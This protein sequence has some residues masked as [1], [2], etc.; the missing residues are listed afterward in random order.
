MAP[1]RSHKYAQA[2]C[3]I[4]TTLSRDDIRMLCDG[5]AEQAQSPQFSVRREDDRP[6]FLVYKI[7]TRIGGV[8]KRGEK[9]TFR[10]DLADRED[11][12]LIKTSILNYTLQRSWPMPWQMVAWGNYKK[13]MNTLVLLVSSRDAS[14]TTSVVES[15]ANA[16]SV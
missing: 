5:A 9:M 10:V 6:E 4:T 14:C 15:A 3:K 11:S 7:R 2:S 13:F 8:G 16:A 1:A 12:T